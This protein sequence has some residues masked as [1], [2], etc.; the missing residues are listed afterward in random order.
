MSS[1][2]RVG[3]V[4]LQPGKS[5][6][7]R[8]HIPALRLLSDR[9]AI[10][11]VANTSLASAQRAAEACDIPL[12]FE[13]VQA[14]AASPEIDMISVTVRVPY[15]LGLVRAAAV[16]GKHVYCEWPLGNGLAEG[17]EMARMVR[18]AGVLGIAGTQARVSPVIRYVRDLLRDGYVGRVLSSTVT[19]RGRSWGPVHD[20][21]A[22]RGYLLDN[23]NGASMLTIPIGHTLAAIRDV[24]GDISEV[25]AVVDNR[26]KTILLPETGAMVPFDTPDQVAVQARVGDGILLTMHY[27]GGMPRDGQGLCWEINGTDGDLRITGLHGGTQQVDL[28]LQGGQGQDGAWRD[29]EVPVEYTAGPWAENINPAN[30][31]RLY[32]RMAD[33][34]RNGTRT[35]PTFDDAVELHR[36]LETITR[37]SAEG[38]RLAVDAPNR[39]LDA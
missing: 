29:L 31:G 32:A 5:W 35:A 10:M 25:A 15:H 34:I 28:Q 27:R 21:A 11:G 13:N 7:A 18:D 14:M 2:I 19:A 39:P 17:Q 37:A 9:F 36:I 33:D 4:G 8:S 22:A 3:F 12:A 38:R 24:L 6:A 26:R 30:V 20:D 23:R 16:A 1:K